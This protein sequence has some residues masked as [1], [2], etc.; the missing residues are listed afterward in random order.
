MTRDGLQRDH[1]ALEHLSSD[2]ADTPPSTIVHPFWGFR[3]LQ[4]IPYAVIALF[5]AGLVVTG[6][7]R[8]RLHDPIPIVGYVGI[9]DGRFFV[10]S[11]VPVLVFSR[12]N[13]VFSS[14]V[15]LKPQWLAWAIGLE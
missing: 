6:V 2:A 15:G 13:V 14:F 5:L 10:L 12:A 4:A 1:D 3:R 7:D 9:L 11:S 8:L